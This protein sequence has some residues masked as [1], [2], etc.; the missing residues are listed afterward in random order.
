M[1][2]LFIIFHLFKRL[3]IRDNGMFISFEV[4]DMGLVI[5]WDKGNSIYIRLKPKWRGRVQGLCGNF[6]FDGSDDFKT[7]SGLIEGSSDIFGD[8]WKL[9]KYCPKAAIIQVSEKGRFSLVLW[10][11]VR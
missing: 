11:N 5:Q 10:D 6:N 8:S 2:D 4:Y 1:F 3:E 9:H 7:P